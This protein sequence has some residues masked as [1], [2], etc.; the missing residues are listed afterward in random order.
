MC[1]LNFCF[2]W[3]WLTDEQ[4]THLQWDQG[5]YDAYAKVMDKF[6]GYNNV[7]GFFIANEGIAA[8]GQSQVAPY[9][10]AAARDMKAYRDNKGYRKIPIGYS[11]AHIVEMQ[12]MLQDFLTC[13]GDD[14][15]I[16]DFYAINS[17]SWCDPSTYENSAYDK[18]QKY[19]QDFPVPIFFSETGCN[20]HPPRLFGDQDAIFGKE[21]INDISGALIYEWI[22]ETNN[23]GLVTYGKADSGPD[24]EEGFVRKGT[25]TPVVPDFENL[26]S[27][28]ATIKPTGVKKADYTPKPSTRPCPS[29][30]D[31]GWWQ[32]PGNVKLPTIGQAF[33]GSYSTAAPSPTGSSTG[34][35]GGNDSGSPSKTQG[36]GDAGKDGKDG[37]GDKS[38][39]IRDKQI[40]VAGSALSALVLGAALL[41]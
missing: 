35:T 32:V 39:A 6:H 4:Q 29:S 3:Q 33:T 13:G 25:P 17:Y 40:T 30:T 15:N 11:A 34:K 22:E 26:K 9:L 24:V 14:K 1:I 36:S 27:K 41:L 20:T 31:G 37:K 23:Y 10:K 18:L 38:A 12:P 8:R 16:I 21:M 7:L 2:H 19:A 5:Q 28:W